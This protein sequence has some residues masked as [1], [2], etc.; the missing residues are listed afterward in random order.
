MQRPLALVTGAS[1]GIGAAVARELSRAGA[2]VLLA[3]RSLD[4][5]RA[6]AA[7]LEQA[8]GVARAV[9]L[10]VTSPESIRAAR[11]EIESFEPDLGPLTWLVNNA[12]IAVSQ[13]LLMPGRDTD[14]LVE[15]L[16]AVNFD[17]ARR[18]A[19]AFLPGMKRR[20][21]GSV[22][23]VVSSAGLRGY[24]YVSAYCASKFALIGWTLA[25][26]EELRASNVTVNAVCPHYVDTAML[27]RSIDTL[28]EKTGRT[29]EEARRFF[30]EQN[31]GQRLVAPE[32]VA[33][34]VLRLC[35]G[36]QTGALLEL[37][38][39][40]DPLIHQPNERRCAWTS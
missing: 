32:E 21:Q 14:E 4:A 8:G 36:S 24:A 40:D 25:A 1:R 29:P 16:M 13:P 2:A 30:A 11:D 38:G 19:E 17:G 15:R 33:R 10:D 18:V 3:A 27:G 20:K 6:L 7:E 31:P 5:C 22:A 37:D 23:N 28:V 34:A 9:A 39:G 35:Q 12:G 26:A